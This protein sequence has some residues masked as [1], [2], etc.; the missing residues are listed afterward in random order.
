MTETRI[1]MGEIEGWAQEARKFASGDRG[2]RG[3]KIE[4][5]WHNVIGTVADLDKLDQTFQQGM[6]VKFTE[7]KNKRGYWDVEGDIEQIEKKEAYSAPSNPNSTKPTTS[8]APKNL[9]VV[10]SFNENRQKDILFQ[11]AFK[12][13]VELMK[14]WYQNNHGII[15]LDKVTTGTIAETG[16][17]Y[18]ALK[19]KRIQ[20]QKAEEW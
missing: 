6:F 2:S 14:L 15:D 7:K 12:G 8:E 10:Q 18:M 16:K 4:G 19:E 11:V 1:I 9:Q 3:L 13:A 17:L 20:L 5:D